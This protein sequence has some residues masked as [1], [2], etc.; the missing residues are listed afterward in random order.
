MSTQTIGII[1]IGLCAAISLL[2][3]FISAHKAMKQNDKVLAA[4][5]VVFIVCGIAILL[6][7]NGI[8]K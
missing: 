5:A 7:L 8:T 3:G 2:Q 1:C 6:C 4:F